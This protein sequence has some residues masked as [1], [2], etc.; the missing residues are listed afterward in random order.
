MWCVSTGHDDLL[1]SGLPVKVTALGGLAGLLVLV[2]SVGH[3]E[4][5][6]GWASKDYGL[7]QVELI[8]QQVQRQ[9]AEVGLRPSEL[10][11]DGE[12][13]RR[14]YLDVLGRIP[15][16]AELR[17]FVRDRDA[18]KGRQLVDR[19][20]TDDR[21]R[22]TFARNWSTIWTNILIGRG[23]GTRRN[24]LTSREGMQDYLHAAFAENKPYDRLVYELVTATGTTVPGTEDFNGATNFLVEKVNDDKAV[25][26]AAQTARIFMGMQIQCTQCHNHPFNDWKQRKF[27][28]LD[29]FFRQTHARRRYA[30]GSRK[31]LSAEL[32]DRDFRGEGSQPG[33]AEIYYELRN[34]ELQVAYPVFVDGT[35][36]AHSGR[37]REVNRRVELARLIVNS[38]MLEKTMVNRTWSH[39]LGY[40]FTRP[41]DDF[42][43]HNP[44][45]NGQLLDGLAAQFRQS[46]F[47]IKKLIRWIV[48]SR[49]YAL[50]SRTNSTNAQQDD[51]V[52]GRCRGSVV[53]ICVRCRPSS[54]MNRC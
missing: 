9:W 19:L 11:T 24:S 54:Y 35:A 27:W 1:L 16:V 51:P 36:I 33:D 29:A 10:A 7:P 50:S 5:R 52:A 37:I 48:L 42:G 8:N 25:Q 47:D 3:A 43:P 40:G 39:F 26:A 21:Y 15:S 23:G 14:L 46:S 13:C 32:F 53:S 28:E 18:D 41:V 4:A 12:W 22:E 2:A 17:E 44:P 31:F 20:L 38:P 30:P 6:S 49:P 45:S 34:G